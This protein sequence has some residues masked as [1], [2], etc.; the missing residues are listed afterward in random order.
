MVQWND[1]ETTQRSR[2]GE[3][4]ILT[5]EQVRFHA[6]GHLAGAAIIAKTYPDAAKDILAVVDEYVNHAKVVAPDAIK[7]K[8]RGAIKDPA[9]SLADLMLLESWFVHPM[10]TLIEKG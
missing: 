5:T 1:L 8:V 9:N 4:M 7:E 10:N 2:N 6:A 3:L